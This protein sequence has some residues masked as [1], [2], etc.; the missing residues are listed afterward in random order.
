MRI[1]LFISYQTKLA[2]NMYVYPA[3]RLEYHNRIFDRQRA[4]IAM[5]PGAEE[6]VSRRDVVVRW[7]HLFWKIWWAHYRVD[8]HALFPWSRRL[9]RVKYEMHGHMHIDQNPRKR[10]LSGRGF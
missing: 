8:A 2:S 6:F 9:T 5:G 4:G 10:G 1:V 7:Q 3:A